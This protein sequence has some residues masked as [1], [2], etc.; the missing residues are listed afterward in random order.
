MPPEVLRGDINRTRE[1]IDS[2]N[3]KWTYSTGVMSFAPEDNPTEAQQSALMDDFERLAFPGLWQYQYDMMW[4]RHRHTSEVRVELH[5]S[6]PRT[7]LSSGKAFNIAPP[8]WEKSYAPLRDTYNYQHGW[9]RP[10]DPNRSRSLQKP[11]ETELRGHTRE[12]ISDYVENAILNGAV[13]DRADVLS[14][15]QG[16]GLETPRAGKTYV[17]ARDPETG[18]RWRL[19]GRIFEQDWTR[20]EEFERTAPRENHPREGGGRGRDAA[21]AEAARGRLEAIIAGRADW[22]RER[23]PDASEVHSGRG[24]G[25]QNRDG[26]R[27]KPDLREAPQIDPVQQPDRGDSGGNDHRS[28]RNLDDAEAPKRGG[29]TGTKRDV[30]DVASQRRDG[31]D[32]SGQTLREIEGVTD[33]QPHTDRESALS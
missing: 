17:T 13:N 20:D 11:F 31:M 7:E 18:E 5:F 25:A 33:E 10:D 12:T 14:A 15:L 4:V 29:A 32:L 26:T 3:R 23:Y 22:V 30:S 6:T 28:A 16:A 1:L 27:L 8:G 21:R 24:E 9:A 2:S 19:K